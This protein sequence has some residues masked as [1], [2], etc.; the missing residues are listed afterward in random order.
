MAGVKGRS[1][2]KPYLQEKTTEEILQLSAMTII[3][4]LKDE[5]LKLEFRADLASKIYIKAMPSRIE[6]EGIADTNIVQVYIP[7][8]SDGLET[9]QRAADIIPSEPGV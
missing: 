3:H 8:I 6:G 1:G 5:T 2:R 7:Q 4:A 9:S